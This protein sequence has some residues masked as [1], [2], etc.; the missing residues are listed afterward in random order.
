MKTI[1]FVLFFLLSLLSFSFASYVEFQYQP[2]QEACNSSTYQVYYIE[3][4]NDCFLNTNGEY[5]KYVQNGNDLDFYLCDSSCNNCNYTSYDLGSYCGLSI[6]DDL[7]DPDVLGDGVYEII[8]FGSSTCATSSRKA[9]IFYPSGCYLVYTSMYIDT[10]QLA[11]CQNSVA[12]IV[13]NCDF[14]CTGSNCYSP[15]TYDVTDCVHYTYPPENFSKRFYCAGF[16][17]QLS[18]NFGIRITSYFGLIFLLL[19]ISWV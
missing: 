19:S 13:S 18:A 17:P 3:L 15:T 11:A 7:P 16:P 8:Y 9:Y 10:Y 5:N 4:T 6:V 14:N 12:S 2:F 1:I